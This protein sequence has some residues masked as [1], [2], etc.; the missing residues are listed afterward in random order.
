MGEAADG[1]PA[2]ERAQRVALA[3]SRRLLYVGMT[4]ARDQLVLVAREGKS[5]IACGWLDD[6]QAGSEVP[7][8][9][10]PAGVEDGDTCD[11]LA[12]A[13]VAPVAALV[14]R[15][16]VEEA[17]PVVERQPEVWFERVEDGGDLAARPKLLL[18][19]SKA[20]F[21]DD[22]EGVAGAAGSHVVGAPFDVYPGVEWLVVG[23]A[24]HLF[25]GADLVRPAADR[26]GHAA[27]VLDAYGLSGAVR[28]ET[29]VA[30]SDRLRSWQEE[31]YPG[32]ALLTEV[33]LLGTVE[34]A[35]G[36]RTL[37]GFADLVLETPQGLVLVDHKCYPAGDDPHSKEIAVGYA[38]QLLGYATLI[39]MATGREVV[40][41]LVHFPFAGKLVEVEVER[42][43]P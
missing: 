39:E 21:P 17:L 5:G 29:C 22:V 18:G 20:R 19:C 35:A 14:R 41:T 6:L 27:G 7:I 11:V 15:L 34:T 3:E 16:T 2:S 4:R 42:R 1:H 23:N 40:A 30:V 31:T 28:P 37:M 43:I 24:I 13:G 33:P 32:A 10:L 26:L 8:F 9:N 12:E 38:P 25:L 36:P